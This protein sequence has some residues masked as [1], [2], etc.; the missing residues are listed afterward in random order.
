[1]GTNYDLDLLMAHYKFV[2]MERAADHIRQVK[3][4]HQEMLD[5]LSRSI[6]IT[7]IETPEAVSPDGKEVRHS[8]R[9]RRN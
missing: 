5:A 9:I 7:E 3:E 2:D 4:A 6:D 8:S 1:M